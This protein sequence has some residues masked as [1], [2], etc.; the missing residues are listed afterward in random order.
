VPL[1]Q[2]GVWRPDEPL[3]GRKKELADV[4]RLVRRDGVRLITVTGP[5]GV[6]KRRFAAEVAVELGDAADATIGTAEEPLG[7]AGERPYRLRPLAEAPAVELFRQRADAAVP[8]FVADYAELADLCRRLA[9]L[10]LSIELVAARGRAALHE[11]LDRR[12]NLREAIEWTY[13]L[14]DERARAALRAVAAEPSAAD[15]EVAVDELVELRLVTRS[16]A[17]VLMHPAIR[18]FAASA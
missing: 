12:W 3:V 15:T 7:L 6:G 8:G 16:D 11:P 18:E 10:P 2:T 1:I 17:G 9:R 5:S 4:L 13:D 14:L